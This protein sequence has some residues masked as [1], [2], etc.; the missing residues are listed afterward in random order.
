M[1]KQITLSLVVI[2]TTLFIQSAHAQW[3]TATLT[4]GRVKLAAAASGNKAIFAGGIGMISVPPGVSD[5]YTS[6]TNTWM[7]STLSKGR[8]SLAGAGANNKILF[9]GGADDNIFLI[10]D[11][12]CIYGVTVG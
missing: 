6:T 2:L 9:A 4:S 1:K 8:T 3:S 12:V 11:M 10:L 7:G 5:I